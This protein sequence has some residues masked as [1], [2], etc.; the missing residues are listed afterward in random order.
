MTDAVKISVRGITKTYAGVAV[1]DHIDLDIRHGEFL[2][3][4]GA[5]GSGKTTLMRVIA[6]LESCDAGSV[7]IDGRDVTFEPPRRR[8]LGMVFQQYSLF[9]HMTIEENIQYGMKVKGWKAAAMKQR[10]TEMLEMIQLPDIAQR[11]PSQ[12]SGGQQQRVA[13]ARALA[14]SPDVLMLDE[15][16]GALDLKLR[17][18]L[19]I[20]LKH[21][22][23]Q[24][25]TTFLF[26]THDQ[27]EA[28]SMSDRIAVLRNGKIEQL[29]STH[30]LYESPATPFVAD[31][32]GEVSLLPCLKNGAGDTAA[33]ENT[34]FVVSAPHAPAGR[35]H[36]AVRPEHVKLLADG[37]TTAGA[38]DVWPARVEEVHFAGGSSIVHL[39]LDGGQ[40]GGIALKSRVLGMPP[41]HVAPGARIRAHIVGEPVALPAN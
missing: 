31:F 17:K 41:A 4:L 7:H 15:P 5:S 24:T 36:L 25:G 8:N 13:L 22:H 23:K 32:I 38:A 14:T 37:D 33:V 10:T 35:F 19:Q 3:L 40:Q 1:N 12:L 6:G 39:T 29:D 2:T 11:Y 9:P 34:A 21:I 30:A 28:L 27:D 26:V 16:L 18:Q 20:E